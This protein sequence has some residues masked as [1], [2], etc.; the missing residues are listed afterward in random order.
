MQA[1]DMILAGLE[2]EEFVAD[3]LADEDAT[4]VLVDDGLFVLLRTQTHV[5]GQLLL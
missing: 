1:T 2:E 5:R 3:A 4:G